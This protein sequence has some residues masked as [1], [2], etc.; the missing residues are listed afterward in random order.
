MFTQRHVRLQERVGTALGFLLAYAIFTTAL[1]VL[2]K[3]T[4]KLPTQWTLTHIAFITLA[5]VAAAALVRR[6]L[7]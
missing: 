6:L 5:I 3:L 2:L 7:R 1:F 4:N